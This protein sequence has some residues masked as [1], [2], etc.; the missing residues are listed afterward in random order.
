MPVTKITVS[1]TTETAGRHRHAIITKGNESRNTSP[2]PA[3]GDEADNVGYTE[4][5]G[6]HA[7]NFSGIGQFG[8][9]IAHNNMQPYQVIYRWVRVA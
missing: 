7:H 4:Y 1:G 8:G 3:Y 5:D 2:Q 6:D 9:S